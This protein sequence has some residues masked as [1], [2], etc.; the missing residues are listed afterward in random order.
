MTSRIAQYSARLIEA[1]WLAAVMVVPLF[2]DVWSNRVFEPDKLTLLRSIALAMAAAALALRLEKGMPARGAV[3]TWL[4]TPLVWPVLLLSVVYAVATATSI[5]PW[6]SLTGSY[7]RLQGLYTWLSYV[8]VFLAIVALVRER[9]QVDRLVTALI[10]PSLP[11][12]LY[13]VVQRF[14]AD[15]MP[16]LGDVTQRVASTMGNSIFVAAYLIMV[17]PLTVA[18]L[19]AALRQLD[20]HAEGAG[21]YAAILRVAG[22]LV[23]V[24]FQIGAIV[25]SQSRGPWLGFYGGLF[26]FF[27]PLVAYLYGGRRTMLAVVTAFVV[28]PSL[29]LL[30]FN[31]PGTPLAPLRDVPYIG[32]LGRVLETERG[33]GKV[34]VLIWD[35]AVDLI[36]SDPKR[37]V[38][39]WGPESMHWAYNPF[40]PPELGN[41]ESRNASPDRSHNEAFDALVTT[42][43][44]G[45]VAYLLL[46]T[47]LFYHGLRW[48]GLIASGSQRTLFLGLWFGGGALAALGFQLWAGKATFFGV[49]LPAGMIAGFFAYVL[50]H[51]LR[52]WQPPARPGRLLMLGLLAGLIAHFIEIH[53]GI[54]IAATRTLFFAMTALLVVLGS[55]DDIPLALAEDPAPSEATPAPTAARRDPRR[56]RAAA[57]RAAA[58]GVG[59]TW[60]WAS[61]AFLLVTV[62][63]TLSFDFVVTPRPERSDLG[64]LLWLLG[65]TWAIGSL[66]VVTETVATLVRQHR[67]NAEARANGA[68]T[69]GGLTLSLPLVYAFSHWSLLGTAT[70]GSTADTSSALLVL[71]HLM[72]VIVLLAWA[73]VLVRGDPTPPRFARGRVVWL[74]PVAG[75]AVL[76]AAFLTNINEVRADVYYKEGWNYYHANQAYDEAVADYNRSLALDPQEDYYMLFKGKALLEKADIEAGQFEDRHADA[77]GAPDFSEYTTSGD[78]RDEAAARDRAFEA[79]V[80]A[81]EE[82]RAQ[83]PRNT[84]HYANLARAYQIWGERTFDKDKRAERL[85][86][87]REW[88]DQAISPAFSPNNAGLREELATTEFLDGNIDA[89]M[90]RIDDALAIDPAYKQPHRVRARFYREMEQW[91]KAAA[92]YRVYL[93]SREGASDTAAWSELAYALGQAEN[94]AGA[95]DANLKVLELTTAAGRPDLTTLGNLAI[96]AR[97]QGEREEACGYVRQGLDWQ[98]EQRERAEAQGLQASSPDDVLMSLDVDLGCGAGAAEPSGD[99]AAGAAGDPDASVPG[100]AAPP[101]GGTAP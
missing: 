62:L 57:R 90:A 74:Y 43:V 98:A 54:A 95:K 83:A 75:A 64:I 84:D 8:V 16:W 31:L 10:L 78:I 35:G 53:F 36:T 86:T 85:Q 47:S 89:A 66:L 32:R 67:W 37:M 40:Y 56:R 100:P 59:P 19:I 45:F 38:V 13:G 34:R 91:D 71:Y 101:A 21:V 99:D 76:V 4:A 96:I 30:A 22:Y 23:L 55:R 5:T 58:G 15:P 26:V 70:A 68:L 14:G 93:E 50:I 6:L 48:L 80:A 61:Q 69:Y 12:A 9:Q 27:L 73:W 94:L 25:L 3:R 18:R 46:F 28:L 82:A 77:V 44:V 51:A 92:D 63:V 20:E 87:S 49:A 39:G 42:G 29:F 88:F 72:L 65:L 81:L 79:A 24:A 7:N 52:G 17:V 97:D 11:V 60:T 2:F 41:Y 33:T 1:G